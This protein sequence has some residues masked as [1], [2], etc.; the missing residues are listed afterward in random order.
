[1]TPRQE[2][3]EEKRKAR[4]LMCYHFPNR[5]A[6]GNMYRYWKDVWEKA[7]EKLITKSYKNL[8]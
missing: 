5:D 7:N 2:L 1:M 8:K 3:I 6:M 4:Q